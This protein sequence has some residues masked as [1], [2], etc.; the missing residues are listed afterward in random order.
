M[1][2]IRIFHNHNFCDRYRYSE[3]V[4]ILSIQLNS[5]ANTTNELRCVIELFIMVK[6]GNL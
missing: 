1:K 2:T 4:Q 6:E 5:I 3:V